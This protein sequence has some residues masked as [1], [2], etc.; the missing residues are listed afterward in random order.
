M[1]RV[2]RC[3]PVVLGAGGDEHRHRRQQRRRVVQVGDHDHLGRGVALAEAHVPHPHERARVGDPRLGAVLGQLEAE[4]FVAGARVP[5]AAFPELADHLDPDGD[6][7][8][9]VLAEVLGARLEDA[10]HPH[11]GGLGR[12]ALDLRAG[13]GHHPPLDLGDVAGVHGVHE[14]DDHVGLVLPGERAAEVP[15]GLGVDRLRRRGDRA[16]RDDLVGLGHAGRAGG[17]PTQHRQDDDGTE[18]TTWAASHRR[19]PPGRAP[20]RA[21][22]R[23]PGRPPAPAWGRWPAG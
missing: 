20:A 17:Q 12:P 2:S 15:D 3:L 21:A 11:G 5:V 7:Q 16:D 1:A 14:P 10:V 4:Q 8:P 19:R 18:E 9:V 13:A 6:D 23:P 22:S